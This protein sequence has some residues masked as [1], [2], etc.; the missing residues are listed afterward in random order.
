MPLLWTENY[1]AWYDTWGKPHN[2]RDIKEISYEVLRFFAVGG[3]GVNYYM[4]HGGTNFERDGMFLQTTSYDFDAPIDECGLV[5]RKYEHFKKLH[6][7]LLENQDILLEGKLLKK[8]KDGICLYI[9]EKGDKSLL[10][11]ING[12]PC[13]K[14]SKI[15][16]GSFELPE[17]S[18]A[19]FK[20]NKKGI[21]KR[22]F[23]TW[24]LPPEISREMI[25][26]RKKL[27]WKMRKEFL[28]SQLLS[29][30]AR[31]KFYF[32]SLQNA[33][34]FTKDKTDY[35]WY[36]TVVKISKSKTAKLTLSNVGDR[37]SLW[38]NGIYAG[39]KPERLQ[40]NNRID[41]KAEFSLHLKKGCNRITIMV[42]ALGL[43]KGDWMLD[44]P[45]SQEKKGLWGDV[46]LDGKRIQENWIFETGLQGERI[47]CFEPETASILRWETISKKRGPLCWYKTNF[48]V[49]YKD[50]SDSAPW[51]LYIGKLKK[52]FI[53]INGFALGRYWQISSE[54]EVP[55]HY[56]GKGYIVLTGLG[57]PPQIYYHI[58]GELINKKNNTLVI[59]DEEGASP[60]DAYLVR[61]R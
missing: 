54:K 41:F 40:E 7:A 47:R 27:S 56:P 49:S 24:E 55:D 15:K 35:M 5:T 8:K 21:P 2:T 23:A 31:E 25:P 9:W 29:S 28:P 61:R 50:L 53:W 59:F 11:F 39:V 48:S 22:L 18:G 57:K 33:I 30:S 37:A 51:A 38:V 12:T 1:P 43:I 16:S 46:F 42:N 32:D 52:G 36:E 10:F 44:A 45:M 20:Q 13:S 58:P 17:F 19:L 14:V 6:L 26:C 60:E 3:S 4:W 34:S